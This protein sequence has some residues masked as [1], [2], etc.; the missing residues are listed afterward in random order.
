MKK[1]VILICF[2]LFLQ[3]GCLNSKEAETLER[4]V[5]ELEIVLEKHKEEAENRMR[6]L[7]KASKISNLCF[8]ITEGLDRLDSTVYGNKYLIAAH[9]ENAKPEDIMYGYLNLIERIER[10]LQSKSKE[11]MHNGRGKPHR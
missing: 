7:R 1:I 8:P 11:S 6:L 10:D 3:S 2:I 5:K 4:R 9:E